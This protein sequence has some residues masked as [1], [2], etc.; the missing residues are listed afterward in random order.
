MLK[1]FSDA[2]LDKIKKAV[3]KIKGVKSIEVEMIL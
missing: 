3:K 1:T 2:S